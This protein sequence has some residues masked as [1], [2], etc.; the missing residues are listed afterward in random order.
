VDRC[1]GSRRLFIGREHAQAE[2]RWIELCGG[3]RRVNMP[4]WGGFTGCLWDGHALAG[5]LLPTA[6]VVIM[7]VVLA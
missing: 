2:Y 4:W 7:A 1:R 6:A 3:G 5:W